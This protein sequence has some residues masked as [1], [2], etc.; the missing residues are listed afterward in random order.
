MLGVC[1]GRHHHLAR[2][3]LV[4]SRLFVFLVQEA[5]PIDV[6]RQGRGVGVPSNEGPQPVVASPHCQWGPVPEGGQLPEGSPGVPL[7]CSHC[8]AP[9]SP[10]EQ[11]CN[12]GTHRVLTKLIHTGCAH[13]HNHWQGLFTQ[14]TH[15]RTMCNAGRGCR[16][17][18]NVGNAG[19]VSP[20]A[21]AVFACYIWFNRVEA[22]HAVHAAACCVTAERVRSVK[23][24]VT[25]RC[26]TA[27]HVGGCAS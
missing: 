22:A 8:I 19:T 12:V 24:Q 17:K 14:V 4:L 18:L 13:K 15:T 25:T 9:V 21:K 1:N 16:V 3:L 5:Q 23:I 20:A 27:P 10:R 26:R 2:L 6:L 11:V 7:Y